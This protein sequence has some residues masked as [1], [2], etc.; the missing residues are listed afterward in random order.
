MTDVVA[1]LP[2]SRSVPHFLTL[3]PLLLVVAAAGCSD[4]ESTPETSAPA[5]EAGMSHDTTRTEH[6]TSN[7]SE[8][9][10]SSEPELFTAGST[11]AHPDS[12]DVFTS[13]DTFSQASEPHALSSDPWDGGS[14]SNTSVPD[15]AAPSS[16]ESNT[17]WGSAS[18]DGGTTELSGE[19]ADGGAEGPRARLV[20]AD[21]EAWALYIYDIP[22]LELVGQYDGVHFSEHAGF[23]PLNDG[24]VLF[25]DDQNYTLNIHEVFGPIPGDL[26]LLASLASPPVHFAVDPDHQFAAVS[27]MGA[28]EAAD[29]FTLVDLATWETVYTP[30]PTGEPGVLFGGH[31]LTVYHR[32]SEPSA[33][34]AYSF[35]T[36]WSGQVS[37]LDSVTLGMAP[38]GDAIAHASGKLFSAADEGIYV[39][40]A[41]GSEMSE[42]RVIPYE[43]SGRSGGRAF[44]ARLGTTGD[45]LYS[46]LRN[47]GENHELGWRDWTNDVFIADVN[48]ETAIRL[49]V[50]QGLVYRLSE[51]NKFALFAQYHPDGDFAHFLDTDPASPTFH[52]VVASIPLPAMTKMPTGDDASPWE[53]EAFRLT[54]MLPSGRYGFVTQGGDGK[55]VVIDTADMSIAGT[56]DA[57]TPLNYG[58]Y[59]IGMEEGARTAD[60]VGR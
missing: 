13:N 37:L 27:G 19:Q 57:P 23:L 3:L 2:H 4:D 7:V 46:Y 41:D 15:A 33:F 14:R 51:S 22:S 50:G 10:V 25:A 38:H 16:D 55:I 20:V 26:A 39:V 45:Y 34:E 31:P 8:V 6:D 60:S 18:L 9:P 35:D 43:A 11:T 30:I 12:S 54:G 56:I 44:Y 17:R 29:L 28:G 1:M 40:T 32:N 47:D 59:V 5:A 42:P 58:G 49:S 36:L 52:T 24:R 21:P 48:S 53:S